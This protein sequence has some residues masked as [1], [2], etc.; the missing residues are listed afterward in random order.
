MCCMMGML[1]DG[2]AVRRAQPTLTKAF[3]TSIGTSPE[4][5]YKFITV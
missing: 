3:R 5:K 4:S 1:V 2:A